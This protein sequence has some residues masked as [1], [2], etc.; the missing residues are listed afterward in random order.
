MKQ[1]TIRQKTDFI[2]QLVNL[3]LGNPGFIQVS[4]IT[5]MADIVNN[6]N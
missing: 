3:N 4:R 2:I 5:N 1:D 6:I